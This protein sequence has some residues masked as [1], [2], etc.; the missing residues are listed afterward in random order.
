[1]LGE[2]TGELLLTLEASVSWVS[3]KRLEVDEASESSRLLRNED[4][5]ET[6]DEAFR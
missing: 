6:L 4:P 3:R 1:V 2:D 5:E